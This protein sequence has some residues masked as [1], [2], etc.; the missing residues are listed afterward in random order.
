M[1][2][3]PRRPTG[4]DI[5]VWSGRVTDGISRVEAALASGGATSDHIYEVAL[6]EILRLPLS[7]SIL[8]FGA[9]RWKT[10]AVVPLP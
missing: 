9:G 4:R 1:D 10:R 7:G 5:S 6:K 8:D 2:L 3:L